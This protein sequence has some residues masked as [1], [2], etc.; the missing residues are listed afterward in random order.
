MMRRL[1]VDAHLHLQDSCFSDIAEDLISQAKTAGIGRLYCNAVTETDWAAVTG[2]CRTHPDIIPFIGIHPWF[3]TTAVPGWQTRLA[4]LL[5]VMTDRSVGIGETGLDKIRGVDF[6]IQQRCFLDHLDLAADLDL[7]ASIHCV[8]AWGPLLET[9]KAFSARRELPRLMIHS[10]NGSTET[11]KQL[12][13]YGCFISY[14]CTIADENRH[15]LRDTVKQTPITAMMLE[16]DSPYQKCDD[17]K[18]ISYL[19]AA[20]NEPV[21][22]TALYR[23]T[24]K[25]LNMKCHDLSSQLWKNHAI[26]TNQAVDR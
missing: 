16:T 21:A 15:T 25:L 22:V 10:F 13:D 8:K 17:L 7:P 18:D 20:H 1:Y 26:F 11:M 4:D 14:S 12:I 24:A 19:T 3:C 23:Y 9:L 2:L 6:E 5:A